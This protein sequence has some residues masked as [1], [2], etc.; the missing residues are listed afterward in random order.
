MRSLRLIC[1]ILAM[2]AFSLAAHASAI[3]FTETVTGSGF[4]NGSAFSSQL[5]TITGSGDTSA[6]TNPFA[7]SYDLVLTSGTLQ[8]GAAAPVTFTNGLTAFS[9]ANAFRA[10][11][12]DSLSQNTILY[13]LASDLGG[14]DLSTPISV[15][16]TPGINSGIQF[17]TSGGTFILTSDTGNSTFTATPGAATPEPS[18]LLLLATG[19]AGLATA[20]H[21]RKL[22]LT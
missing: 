12:A 21:R 10:G 1:G 18:S 2:S 3:T 19:L 4:L 20:A 22:H 13:T 14:D 11:L 16:G 15:T 17:A 5:I 9:F 7:G 8:I 6:I